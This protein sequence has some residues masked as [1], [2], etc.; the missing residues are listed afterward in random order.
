[1]KQPES[2]K[3][4]T[5]SE[6]KSA[7][8]PS[9]N[10]RITLGDVDEIAK[11]MI[12]GLNQRE[13]CYSIGIKPDTFDKW[14]SLHKNS[15]VFTEA[16]TRMR[17]AYIQGRLKHIHNAEAKD[18]RAADRL[19]QIAAPERYGSKGEQQAPASSGLEVFVIDA[20]K[21]V[22]GEVSPQAQPALGDSPTPKALP[23]SEPAKPFPDKVIDV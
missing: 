15:P 8:K 10:R 4:L 5:V 23:S 3:T 7:Y 21:R 1:M 22:F 2:P 9:Q 14:K 13:A 19:L 6:A 11:L 17:A 12:E 16:L 18:W 20:L